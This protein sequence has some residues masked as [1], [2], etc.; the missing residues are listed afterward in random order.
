MIK[1]FKADSFGLGKHR[2]PQQITAPIAWACNKPA[3]FL[4]QCQRRDEK[5]LFRDLVAQA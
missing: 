5:Q 1:R 3:V 2:R 4:R